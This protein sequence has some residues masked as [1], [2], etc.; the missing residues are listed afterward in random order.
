MRVLSQLYD[1]V[2]GLGLIV[3]AS[4]FP[5]HFDVGICPFAQCVGVAQFIS[6]VL[7]EKIALYITVGTVHTWEEVS[8][9][10]SSPS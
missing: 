2:P 8:S 5:T 1:S 4:S 9:G 7:S 3:C 10:A 6:G